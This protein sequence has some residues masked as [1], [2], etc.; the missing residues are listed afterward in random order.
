LNNSLQVNCQIT[1]I[2][3]NGNKVDK[4]KCGGYQNPPFKFPVVSEVNSLG[5]SKHIHRKQIMAILSSFGNSASTSNVAA[6]NTAANTSFE[7]G[8]QSNERILAFNLNPSSSQQISGGEITASG[9][10]RTKTWLTSAAT[11]IMYGEKKGFLNSKLLVAAHVWNGKGF[12]AP[13]SYSQGPDKQYRL[14]PNAE[15]SGIAAEV[16]GE[17]LEFTKGKIAELKAKKKVAIAE[18]E[19]TNQMLI[20]ILAEQSNPETTFS[21]SDLEDTES[22]CYVKMAE[23][24]TLVDSIDGDIEEYT[25]HLKNKD[26]FRGWCENIQVSINL[27][28][29][30]LSQLKS[31]WARLNGG[32]K[33]ILKVKC[34]ISYELAE[35]F[36]IHI[37]GIACDIT[38]GYLAPLSRGKAVGTEEG[39]LKQALAQTHYQQ[40]KK[41]TAGE[42]GKKLLS[43]FINTA[44]E[45]N[46]KTKERN[47][48]RAE[49]RKKAWEA[50]QQAKLMEQM[51]QEQIDVQ[52]KEEPQELVAPEI[53]LD[54]MS[55]L[56]NA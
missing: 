44:K 8:L 16:Y 52:A 42:E 23:C 3:V 5:D 56:F 18:K 48:Y 10:N 50:E 9:A 7:E 40:L 26:Y 31:A 15:P 49:S 37:Q 35:T 24:D 20:H 47:D 19:A 53:Q 22:H 29:L 21:M 1:V 43:A 27:P 12:V 39:N 17:F 14:H 46:K 30:E 2:S 28:G 13:P 41:D 25:A 11:S 6:G 32:S 4:S 54:Q 38:E 51:R 55:D 34:V 33:L 45:G 36:E